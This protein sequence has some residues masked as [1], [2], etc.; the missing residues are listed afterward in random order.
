MHRRFR[1]LVA[2]AALA[3]GLL[4]TACGGSPNASADGVASAGHRSAARKAP[5]KK[6]AD[7]Q[8]AGLDFAKCMRDHGVDMPDP[9]ASEGGR[10]MI[11]DGPVRGSAGVLTELPAG[12]E[13]ADNACR[14][15]LED[16]IGDGPGPIDPKEQDRALKFARC[17]RDNGVE[18]PDP[19]FSGGGVHIT[20]GGPGGP[21]AIS[22]DSAAFQ[23]AQTA[24]GSLFGGGPRA[25]VSSVPGGGA[26][27]VTAGRP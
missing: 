26:L 14:H 9:V 22:V 19:D 15:F 25:G 13:A 10:V 5:D 16:L 6:G 7:S 20:V 8:Q 4:A 24:C 1:T 2:P 27:T 18:M 12:F 23:A 21:G 3:L 17:M 11:G